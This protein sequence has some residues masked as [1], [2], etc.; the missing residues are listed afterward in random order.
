M[1]EI[2]SKT[3]QISKGAIAECCNYDGTI[4]RTH[5]RPRFLI[6]DEVVERGILIFGKTVFAHDWIGRYLDDVGCEL[7][8]IYVTKQCV[9]TARIRLGNRHIGW[10]CSTPNR[11]WIVD[12]KMWFYLYRTMRKTSGLLKVVLRFRTFL[13]KNE[14]NFCKLGCGISLY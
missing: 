2:R 5:P 7:P 9:H 10:C 14:K 4:G 1:F 11:I 3:L 12:V 13:E 6:A 8:L